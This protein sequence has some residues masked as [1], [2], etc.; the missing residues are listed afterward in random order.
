MEYEIKKVDGVIESIVRSDGAC[1]P[2][3]EENKDYREYRRWILEDG[4]VPTEENRVTVIPPVRLALMEKENK[5]KRVKALSDRIMDIIA[6]H[7]IDNELDAT[8]IGLLKEN[9]PMVFTLLT[10]NQPFSAK[11]LLDQITADGVLIT[12]DEIA[13]IQEAY[14]MFAEQNPDIPMS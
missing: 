12:E 13:H 11:L 10:A 2:P 1:I 7:N 6:G 3:T 4:G 5:G 8:Q 14:V 9:H